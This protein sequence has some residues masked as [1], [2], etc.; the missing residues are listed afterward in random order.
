VEDQQVFALITSPDFYLIIF[1]LL[2]VVFLATAIIF[3]IRKI[4]KAIIQE[5]PFQLDI[6]KHV[7]NIGILI[8]ITGVMDIVGQVISNKLLSLEIMV[9]LMNQDPV[10][11]ELQSDFTPFWTGA[12]III[13]SAVFKYGVELKEENNKIKKTI[14]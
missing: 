12:F 14:A 3:L 2:C 5:N 1:L 10:L 7:R 4:I 13:L 8:C 11:I 9:S 6:V